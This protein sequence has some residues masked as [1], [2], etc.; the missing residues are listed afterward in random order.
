MFGLFPEPLYVWGSL[1]RVWS[2]YAPEP[3][4][5]EKTA[6]RQFLEQKVKVINCNLSTTTWH[7]P[8]YP[9]KGFVGKC[10]YFVKD[11]ENWLSLLTTLAKFAQ[12]AGVGYKTTMGMGQSRL[13]N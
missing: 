10:T 11:N 9:Q 1:G 2:T 3:F 5:F 13:S 12:F 4:S 8:D 7:Y 6:F